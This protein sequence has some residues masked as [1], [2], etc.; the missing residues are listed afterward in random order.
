MTA[1]A[2]RRGFLRGLVSLPLVGGGVAILGDP[3][4]VAAPVT[5]RLLGAY[6]E[7]LRVERNLLHLELFPDADP[8]ARP[9]L[10]PPGAGAARHFHA[11]PHPG[12]WRDLPPASA[13]AAL[14]S[15]AV[16]CDWRRA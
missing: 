10:V 6:S 13:R 1:P 4:A 11:P 8:R 7:W 15:S 14:V 9:Y 16:G 2:S 5:P 12:S 3:M